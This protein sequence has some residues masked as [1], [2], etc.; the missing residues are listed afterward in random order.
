MPRILTFRSRGRFFFLQ[1]CAE[2]IS[3]EKTKFGFECQGDVYAIN[4]RFGENA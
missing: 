4:N 3:S 1:L 2:T